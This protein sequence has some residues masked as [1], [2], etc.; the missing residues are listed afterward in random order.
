MKD[1]VYKKI[2]DLCQKKNAFETSFYKVHYEYTFHK[3]DANDITHIELDVARRMK[4]IYMSRRMKEITE[5]MW[6]ETRDFTLLP[7]SFINQFNEEQ[8][9]EICGLSFENFINIDKIVLMID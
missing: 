5:K 3:I 9:F 7:K 1:G 8:Q 2:C 6:L 4:I